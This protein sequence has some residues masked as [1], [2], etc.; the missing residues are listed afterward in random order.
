VTPTEEKIIGIIPGLQYRKGLF[1]SQ[2]VDLIVTSHRIILA[3]LTNKMMTEMAAAAAKSAKAEGRGILGQIMQSMST[4]FNY[5]ARYA[6]MTIEQ[7]ATETPGNQ[8]IELRAI[9]S[10]RLQSGDSDD[11]SPNK[12]VLTTT[13]GKMTFNSRGLQTRQT[14]DLLRQVVPD[15]R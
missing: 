3:I 15:T 8:S 2:P 13:S 7:I 1:S 6:T 9:R 11:N 5:H 14:R 10:I 4:G 12:L